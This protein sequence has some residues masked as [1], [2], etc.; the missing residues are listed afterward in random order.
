MIRSRS[1]CWMAASL[2]AVFALTSW[3]AATPTSPHAETLSALL[4]PENTA[5]VSQDFPTVENVF[6]F[7]LDGLR[8]SEGIKDPDHDLIPN[9]W[10]K[11]RPQG[12]LY[13]N[14]FTMGHSATSSG[15]GAILSGN[16]QFMGNTV[17]PWYGTVPLFGNDPS[18][19]QYF[20]EQTGEPAEKAWLINGKGDIIQWTGVSRNPFYQR[21]FA[22]SVAYNVGT[23]DHIVNADARE[24][25]STHKPRLALINFQNADL[26][27]HHKLWHGYVN[28]IKNADNLIFNLIRAIEQDPHYTSKTAYFVTTDHGRH[29]PEVQTGYQDHYGNCTGCRE[30]FLLALGPNIKKGETV[31]RRRHL[32][33]LTPTVGEIMGIDTPHATGSV[34]HEMFELPPTLEAASLFDAEMASGGGI[35]HM[36]LLRESDGYADIYYY[37][38]TAGTEAWGAPSVLSTEKELLAPVIAVDGDHVA[39]AWSHYTPDGENEVVLRQSLDAGET[40]SEPLFLGTIDPYIP[41]YGPD[42]VLNGGDVYVVW[43][44]NTRKINAAHVRGNTLLARETLADFPSE[45]PV[46]APTENG[47]VVLY[48]KYDTGSESFQTRAS[49]FVNGQWMDPVYVARTTNDSM[50]QDLTR[51]PSGYTAVWAEEQHRSNYNVL[52]ADSTDGFTWSAPTVID[53]AS[54][55]AWRPY[56]QANVTGTY[57]VYENYE[58]IEPQ[59]WMATRP[60]GGQ[61][62]AAQAV[63]GAPLNSGSPSLHLGADGSIDVLWSTLP[64]PKSVELVSLDLL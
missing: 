10:N 45:Q 9:I 35:E 57:V 27:A 4:E 22:P 3:W 48:R 25:I 51:T 20:R 63:T 33:D 12:T 2:T 16:T 62:Q 15:H 55:G 58:G 21:S 47:V 49:Q 53:S 56:I 6:I 38:R 52:V 40:W 11:L 18:I 60:A 5:L 54:V 46:C 26:S 44:N 34:L 1:F 61:W 59:V 36:V 13:T 14:I 23:L 7:V 17:I 50:Q 29:L 41:D 31:S 24:I 39:I 32:R 64:W 30:V 43:E 28:N 19:F 8:A 37:N 42:V